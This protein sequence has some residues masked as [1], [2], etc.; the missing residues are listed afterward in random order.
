MKLCIHSQTSAMQPLRFVNWSEIAFHTS[1]S[2]WLLIHVELIHLSLR[3]LVLS[4]SISHEYAHSLGVF[5]VIQSALSTF[6]LF[7]YWFIY[8]DCLIGTG[9]VWLLC[10]GEATLKYIVK[11]SRYLTTTIH[12]NARI[13]DMLLGKYCKAN[14]TDRHTV[15]PLV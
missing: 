5:Y 8:H 3:P 12:D 11:S 15:K 10:K 9:I 6:E 13:V 2:M 1:L 4:H 7:I 14:Y